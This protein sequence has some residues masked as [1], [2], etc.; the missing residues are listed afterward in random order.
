MLRSIHGST[1]DRRCEVGRK[2]PA[3]VL[4]CDKRDVGQYVVMGTIATELIES[5]RDEQAAR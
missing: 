2:R 1:S 3:G 5:K 4:V